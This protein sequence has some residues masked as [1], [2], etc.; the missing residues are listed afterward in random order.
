M[1]QNLELAYNVIILSED[2]EQT[3]IDWPNLVKQGV[4]AA[5]VRLSHGVT[6]DSQAESNLVHA[7][8]IGLVVHGYHEY[9]GLDAEIGFSVDNASELSLPMGAYMFLTN[10]SN[11]SIALSFANNWQAAGWSVGLENA[12]GSY[13]HWIVS[14]SEPDIYDV[15]Q[16]K[17]IRAFDATGRLSIPP[18]NPV[19]EN[20]NAIPGNPAAGA[21]V[22]SGY[23]TTGLLGGQT[24]GYST[25]GVDFYAVITPFGIV[26]RQPDFDRISNGLINKLKLQ[27]PNGNV[28]SLSITDEGHVI[29]TKEE[30]KNVKN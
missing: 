16:F 6:K 23:D 12:S 9:E 3:T 5:I 21:Y 11:E 10:V 24:L 20:D 18:V 28:F 27:S 2:V 19:P 13:Y 7:R 30:D 4:Q 29:T 22:G 8:E 15:W 25:N 17:G 26:F 1:D 14:E